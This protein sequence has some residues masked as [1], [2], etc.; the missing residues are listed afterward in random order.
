M[1]GDSGIR[2]R[3]FRNL[4]IGP[5]RRNPWVRFRKDQN[6]S[7]VNFLFV[8]HFPHSYLLRT[9]DGSQGSP[10]VHPTA[11]SVSGKTTSR[12]TANQSYRTS[13]RRS[14]APSDGHGKT[15]SSRETSP[16]LSSL[17][18]SLPGMGVRVPEPERGPTF[19]GRGR[20]TRRGG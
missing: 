5:S 11:P 9:V 1:S 8:G 7:R 14:N 4:F 20:C 10:L 13:H 19:R 2:G 17:D 6:G 16:Y 12:S 3:D 18:P 15:H